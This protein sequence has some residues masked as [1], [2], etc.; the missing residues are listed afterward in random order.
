MRSSRKLRPREAEAPEEAAPV[1]A[2]AGVAVGPGPADDLTQLAGIGPKSAAAL[3][4]AGISTYAVLAEANEP[5][6]RRALYASDMLPPANVSS[7]PG[8]A[9]YAAKGDWVGLMK[10]NQKTKTAAAPAAGA[11]AAAA[12]P[13]AAPDDLTQIS[14]IGPRLASILSRG[15]VTTYAQLEQMSPDELR[16]IV[17]L[18]GALPPASLSSWPAQASYAVRGDFSG[19]ASYNR[20]R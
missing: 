9:E 8:Q 15:G 2:A 11:A 5:Q 16:E 10:R 7:W 13:A 1:A 3:T 17:A 4:A 18:G 6:I 20:S 12:A 14:G 19:L